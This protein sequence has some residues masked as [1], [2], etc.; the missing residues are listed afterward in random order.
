M[1]QQ[2]SEI[3]FINTPPFDSLAKFVNGSQTLDLVDTNGVTFTLHLGA[4]GDAVK[5]FTFCNESFWGEDCAWSKRGLF[6]NNCKTTQ[7][8]AISIVQNFFDVSRDNITVDV[9]QSK[10]QL[11]VH[12]KEKKDDGWNVIGNVTK[13]SNNDSLLDLLISRGTVLVSEAK[14]EDCFKL[15][16][17][18]RSQPQ[19]HWHSFFDLIQRIN[20]DELD[21]VKKVKS[22]GLDGNDRMRVDVERAIRQCKGGNNLLVMR[23]D[24]DKVI[25]YLEEWKLNL[26]ID[27]DLYVL[28][29]ETQN[30]ATVSSYHLVRKKKL[31]MTLFGNK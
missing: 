16:A 26:D 14:P 11:E 10:F 29:R 5:T 13:L 28:K 1:E 19:A 30:T 21:D 8:R 2:Q 27:Y 7:A 9:T 22:D 15:T 18:E 3:Y 31:A 20:A 25:H 6:P 23:E 17:A 12:H 24:L 4:K